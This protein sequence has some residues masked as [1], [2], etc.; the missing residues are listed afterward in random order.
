[1][2]R[3]EENR[4]SGYN[5]QPVISMLRVIKTDL[6]IKLIYLAGVK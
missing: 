3:S 4:T 5:C 6:Q 2:L 1:M